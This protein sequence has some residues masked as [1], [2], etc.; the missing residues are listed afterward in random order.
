[1]AIALCGTATTAASVRRTNQNPRSCI[2]PIKIIKQKS[3]EKMVAI[4]P[5]FSASQIDALTPGVVK[6]DMAG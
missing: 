3:K 6:K 5:V 1:M 4:T 2:S